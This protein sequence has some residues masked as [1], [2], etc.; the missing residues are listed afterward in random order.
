MHCCVDAFDSSLVAA[1]HTTHVQ[2]LYVHCTLYT[3]H[4]VRETSTNARHNNNKRVEPADIRAT[5]IDCIKKKMFQVLLLISSVLLV[6]VLAHPERRLSS[7]LLNCS[8]YPPVMSYHTHI[9]FMLTSSD[10]IQRAEAL[11]NE[12]K[13][14]F[15]DFMNADPTCKG[16]AEDPSGRYGWFGLVW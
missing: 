3:V 4:F 2:F 6:A 9:V 11:R 12:A 7:G 5:A 15:K 8:D 10:Q 14:A 16:T 1:V 13:I